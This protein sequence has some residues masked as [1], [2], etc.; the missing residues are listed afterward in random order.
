MNADFLMKERCSGGAVPVCNSPHQLVLWCHQWKALS[1]VLWELPVV[2]FY[3]RCLSSPDHPFSFSYLG[4]P[5]IQDVQEHALTD[6]E[7]SCTASVS[8]HSL[9][10]VWAV[11]TRTLC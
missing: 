9:G 1:H 7:W 6:N 4:S 2:R 3:I 10:I 11:A 8:L 5:N